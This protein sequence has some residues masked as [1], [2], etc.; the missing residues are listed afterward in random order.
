MDQNEFIKLFN[1][2]VKVS[3]KEEFR[4]EATKLVWS[5]VQQFPELYRQTRPSLEVYEDEEEFE[6][7]V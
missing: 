7:E 5:L 4:V 3:E 1:F 2:L 6:E